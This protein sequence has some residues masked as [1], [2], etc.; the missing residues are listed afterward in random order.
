[1]FM[2]T[3]DRK[4]MWIGLR[5]SLPHQFDLCKMQGYVFFKY[6]L[7]SSILYKGSTLTNFG[8]LIKEDF[9]Y[10]VPILDFTGLNFGITFICVQNFSSN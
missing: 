6:F 5:T 7:I 3:T 4:I 9:W 8:F 1:M 2:Y 10:V